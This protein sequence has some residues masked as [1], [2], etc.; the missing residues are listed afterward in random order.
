MTRD[1]NVQAAIAHW[2][3][4]LIANG[5]DYN[6]FLTTTARVESWRDWCAEWSRTASL[7]ERLA[8]EAAKRG[9]MASAADAYVRAALCH[10]FGKFVF[11]DDMDA[12]HKASEATVS[13]YA[14][15]LPY[16]DPPGERVLIPTAARSSPA[17]SDGLKARRG[18]RSW[19]SS[20]ALIR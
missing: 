16:L 3:P 1:P 20:A 12:A 11:F 10:H 9:N 4:R 8:E 18:R 15:A 5:I 7:H 19:S 13:N 2:A 14:R 17:I 6:D